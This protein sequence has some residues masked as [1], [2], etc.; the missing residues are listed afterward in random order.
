MT[1]AELI[2]DLKAAGANENTIK[3]ALNCYELGKE[4]MSMQWTDKADEWTDEIAA[5]HPLKTHAYK[6][7]DT[8]MA[9]VGARHSKFALVEL[10]CWLLQKSG[11]QHEGR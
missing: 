8:A 3:L 9:M 11:G 5:H 7:W 4:H 6:Q 1:L 2:T 10:V